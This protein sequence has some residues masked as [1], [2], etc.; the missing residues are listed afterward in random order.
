[1]LMIPG[2]AGLDF[3]VKMT[4]SGL[5]SWSELAIDGVLL[6]SG[7]TVI[8]IGISSIGLFG[9]GI[10]AL[11]GQIDSDELIEYVKK[12]NDN[13]DMDSKMAIW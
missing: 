7:K 11:F 12:H 10:K 8:T 9:N 6:P 2:A 1:M 13:L 4:K 3:I 5:V